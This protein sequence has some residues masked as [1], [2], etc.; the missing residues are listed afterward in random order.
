MATV[1]AR[2]LAGPERHLELTALQLMTINLRQNLRRRIL[3]R[4]LQKIAATDSLAIAGG[5][6]QGVELSKLHICFGTLE[7]ADHTWTDGRMHEA[8][9]IDWS[10]WLVMIDYMWRVL[11]LRLLLHKRGQPIFHLQSVPLPLRRLLAIS[12]ISTWN[13]T[14]RHDD[15]N[16]HMYRCTVLT[17]ASDLLR[18]GEAANDL[19]RY[20]TRHAHLGCWW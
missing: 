4:D 20:C 11:L 1:V 5:G 14:L 17:C 16:N 13:T 19:P 6:S 2:W 9:T 12:D 10:L 18:G 3:G 7:S 15:Y 8:H